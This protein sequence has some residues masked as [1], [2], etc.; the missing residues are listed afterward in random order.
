M[1]LI[2]FVVVGCGVDFDESP[3]PQTFSSFYSK[4]AENAGGVAVVLSSLLYSRD[5][6][7]KCHSPR[8]DQSS[9]VAD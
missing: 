7:K 2:R 8:F 6:K 5:L 4:T 3:S 1:E 9:Q